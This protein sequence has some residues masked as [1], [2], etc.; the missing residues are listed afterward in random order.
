MSDFEDKLNGI[1]SNPDA[2]AQIASLAQSLNLGGEPESAPPSP[3]PASGNSSGG[4]MLGG[5][6]DLLG[7]LDPGMIQKIGRAS[8]RERVFITV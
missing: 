3:A 2:M 5:L 4:G 8:C 1:L 6:G 7:Q